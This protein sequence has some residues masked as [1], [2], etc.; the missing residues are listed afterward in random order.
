MMTKAVSPTKHSQLKKF[1]LAANALG[2]D[3]SEAAFDAKLKKIAKAV[4]PQK[5][6]GKPRP[7]KSRV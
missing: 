3:D 7:R 1:K 5:R 2:A 4:P 6:P